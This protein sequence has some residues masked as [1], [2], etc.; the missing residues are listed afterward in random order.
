M[1]VALR[2]ICAHVEKLHCAAVCP[3]A[4]DLVKAAAG[5]TLGACLC[6]CGK[7]HGAERDIVETVSI[8]GADAVLV[9]DVVVRVVIARRASGFM[10]YVTDVRD[11]TTVD[12]GV[13]C[14]ARAI[15]LS[16]VS[17]IFVANATSAVVTA[18]LTVDAWVH[19]GCGGLGGLGGGRCGGN[20]WGQGRRLGW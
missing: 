9:L 5:R 20:G 18:V 16:N 6:C 19:E 10:A 7:S 4:A 8:N 2:D 14:R 13:A 15:P 1:E 3:V 12:A 11:V 17:L